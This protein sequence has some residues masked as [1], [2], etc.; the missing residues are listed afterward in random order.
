MF[1][2]A[3]GNVEQGGL[4]AV[5]IADQGDADDMVPLL[6]QF[7]HLPVDQGLFVGFHPFQGM[8]DGDVLLR[9]FFADDLDHPRFL[10]AEGEFVAQDLV[11]D[12]V[13]ERGV[14]HHRDLLPGDESHFDQTFA[15]TSVTIDFCDH[16]LFPGL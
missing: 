16:A 13:L 3:R 14:E 8:F 4:A 12:R 6:G 2:A 15:E 11:L 1:M 5:R 7:G 9:F 10:P